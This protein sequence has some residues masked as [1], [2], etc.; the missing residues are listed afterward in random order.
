MVMVMMAVAKEVV[1]E[2]IGEVNAKESHTEY[3]F[4]PVVI[5]LMSNLTEKKID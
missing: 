2:F 5:Q 1:N 4:S 3:Y